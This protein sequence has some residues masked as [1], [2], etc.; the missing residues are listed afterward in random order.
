MALNVSLRLTVYGLWF[1]VYGCL[2]QSLFSHTI[3]V[4]K[5]NRKACAPGGRRRRTQRSAKIGFSNIAI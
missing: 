2:D 1:F 4:E 3:C 5:V